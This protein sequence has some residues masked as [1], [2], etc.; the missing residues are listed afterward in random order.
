MI[1]RIVNEDIAAKMAKP[2]FWVLF[3]EITGA[4]LTQQTF[5]SRHFSGAYQEGYDI[6]GKREYK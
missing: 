5:T 2:I 3:E 4:I 1:G 6:Y